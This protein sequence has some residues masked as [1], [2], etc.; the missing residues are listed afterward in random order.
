M[1]AKRHRNCVADAPGANPARRRSF[2]WFWRRPWCL[3]VLSGLVASAAF[4]PLP[5][6]LNALAIFVALVPLR[7]AVMGAGARAG[8]CCAALSGFTGCAVAF[9]WIVP[10]IRGF[11]GFSLP[12]AVGGFLLW[13][14]WAAAFWAVFGAVW[15]SAWG[16]SA[17]VAVPAVVVLEHLWPRIFPWRFGDPVIELTCL[18]QSADLG[19]VGLVSMLVLLVNE[20]GA[21]LCLRRRDGRGP[22]LAPVAV[23]AAAITASCVYGYFRLSPGAEGE[24][25]VKAA[26]VHTCVPLRVKHAALADLTRHRQGDHHV[27]VPGARYREHEERLLALARESVARDPCDLVVFPEALFAARVDQEPA[28]LAARVGTAVVLG[29]GVHAWDAPGQEWQDFNSMILEDEAGRQLYHKHHLIPF[30]EYIPLSETFEVVRRFFGR[31]SMRRGPGAAVLRTGGVALAPLVCYEVI[32]SDYVR[33]CVNL[34]AEVLVNVTEDGWYGWTG[35]PYQHLMLARFR[36]VENRRFLLRAVNNGISAIVDPCGRLAAYDDARRTPGVV[37][38][39][40]I[41]RRDVTW[42]TR[43]G[44]WWVYVLGVALAAHAAAR[45]ACVRRRANVRGA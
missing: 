36:A 35:E 12:L 2:L 3:S 14:L 27:L 32:L 4:F 37:R 13:L 1:R 15:G 5:L 41:P 39:A 44:A 33:R 34:G 25:A 23:C 17:L 22:S 6:R 7:V 20:A 16:R 24:H 40:F 29:A 31:G 18:A 8:A 19:G 10:L 11:G 30:G 43:W 38:G 9:H 21:R 42:Y 45:R 28:G 26:L